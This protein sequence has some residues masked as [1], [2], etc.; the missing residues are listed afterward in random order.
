M[1]HVSPSSSLDQ[2]CL[3]CTPTPPFFF[4]GPCLSRASR[5]PQYWVFVTQNVRERTSLQYL[6][7]HFLSPTSRPSHIGIFPPPGA[8]VFLPA[9]TRLKFR[10]T[11]EYLNSL[12]T[13]IRT[14]RLLD[15]EVWFFNQLVF[16]ISQLA[17]FVDQIMQKS[18]CRADIQSSRHAISII[19]S[20][21]ELHARFVLQ[22]YC[23]Q[24]DWQLSSMAQICGQLSSS[25]FLCKAGDLRI[26]TTRPLTGPTR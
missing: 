9:L 17:H 26:D 25:G 11:S 18:S 7:L 4:Q 2:N 16:H 10:G 8:R 15:I 22:V 19:F 20:Q 5:N 13:R 23:E 12:V 14:P 24:L 3:S 21:P 6:S 1:R